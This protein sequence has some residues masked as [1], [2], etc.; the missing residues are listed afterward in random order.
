MIKITYIIS[1]INKA[2]AFEWIAQNINPQK[3]ILSFIIIN[4]GTSAL[5]DYLKQQG[6][7]VERITCRGKKDWPATF[8]RTYNLLRR[9][10]PDA[11]HCH[12]I[13]ATIIGLLAA[14][15]AGVGKRI[16]TRH[17]SSLHHMY[18]KKG[19]W[20][21]KLSNKLATRII[22]I[23]GVVK[24]I[25][26]Q[27]ENADPKKVI[28]IPHGFQL[29]VFQT[30]DEARIS[31]FKERHSLTANKPIL[32]VI[33]RFTEWKGV[34]YIVP[35]FQRLLTDFPDAVL[36]LL[37][38]QGDYEKNIVELL[39]QLPPESYRLIPFEQDIA[40]AY[41]S[42]DVFIHAPIDEHSEA[43]GQIY[44]E[45]LAAELPSVFTLSGI[46]PD[47]IQE[48]KNAFVV[49]FKNAD[50]IFEKLLYILNNY[51]AAKIIAQQGKSDVQELFSLDKMIHSLE[52]LYEQR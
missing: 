7:K 46:A 12:L 48:G 1:D 10:K 6:Y 3:F 24:E 47:F 20:W 39:Q 36:L 51:S 40:A 43:F 23:A 42:M 33:S 25:L 31:S 49:P 32:G 38:A 30:V 44:V 45:A 17:H 41:K 52:A 29:D 16:Y 9:W 37:N 13:Q 28:L 2:L 4:P 18:F 5:E 19:V 8:V 50:V 15:L 35:A 21:D 11:V 14:S 22:A 26:I 34:Q 27:W